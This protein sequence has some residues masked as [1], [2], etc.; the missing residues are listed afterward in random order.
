M[1]ECSPLHAKLPRDCRGWQL[2]GLE[3]DDGVA[4]LRLGE[5]LAGCPPDPPP[6]L[7]LVDPG[8]EELLRPWVAKSPDGAGDALA[9]LEEMIDGGALLVVA[10]APVPARP[11]RPLAALEA[12]SIPAVK[13]SPGGVAQLVDDRCAAEVILDE[14]LYGASPILWRVHLRLLP[15]LFWYGITSASPF[16]SLPA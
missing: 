3:L 14:Q 12:I 2:A 13:A 4:D 8:S 5:L 7:E 11:E 6:G 16:C 10:V 9:V 15:N 1:V